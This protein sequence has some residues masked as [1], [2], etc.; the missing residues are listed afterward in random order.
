MPAGVLNVVTG[1]GEEAG[2]GLALHDDVDVLAFT[3]SGV[4]GRKLLESSARS[5][6]WKRG[7]DLYLRSY[8]GWPNKDSKAHGN[9][10]S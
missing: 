9:P 10:P 4:V 5:N 2:A 1:S 8:A 7:L 3:G 6:R